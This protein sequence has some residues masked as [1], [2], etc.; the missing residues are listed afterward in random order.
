MISAVIGNEDCDVVNKVLGD[1]GCL[2]SGG[3]YGGSSCRRLERL[4]R[5]GQFLLKPEQ[6]GC[7]YTIG[8]SS[9]LTNRCSMVT[10]GACT[11]PNVKPLG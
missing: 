5:I 4:D 2:G 9:V 11:P 1:M 7:A 10:C 8:R 6:F 3:E